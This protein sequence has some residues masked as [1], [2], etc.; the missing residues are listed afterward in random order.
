[1][2]GAKKFIWAVPALLAFI[3]AARAESLDCNNPPDT[4]SENQCADLAFAKADK[5]LNA[6]WRKVK[7]WAAQSDA[8]SD[9]PNAH[10]YS[11][12]VLAAQRAWLSYRDAVCAEAGLPMHGGTGEGPLVGNCRAT[13]TE[14]RVKSLKDLLPP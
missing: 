11:N 5:E 14:D 8:E 10:D 13:L 6:V 12:T 3:V 2:G 7:D 4:A 1:M 9:N